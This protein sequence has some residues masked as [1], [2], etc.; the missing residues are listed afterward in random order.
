ME[1]KNATFSQLTN[2]VYT[3]TRIDK[4]MYNINI[5]FLSEPLNNLPTTKFPIDDDYS[6]KFVM[7]EW[8][9]YKVI[10]VDMIC[11]NTGVCGGNQDAGV[12]I[13]LTL[14]RSPL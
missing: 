12:D 2:I 1:N 3:V 14:A 9:R 13:P 6:V 5:H 11:K 4:T 8:G 10:Y 7:C